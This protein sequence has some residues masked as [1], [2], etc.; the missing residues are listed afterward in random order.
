MFSF[1][2]SPMLE[3]LE[4]FVQ[5]GVSKEIVE[6][7]FSCNRNMAKVSNRNSDQDDVFSNNV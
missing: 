6:Y 2:L 1:V 3:W 7:P 5:N 4:R